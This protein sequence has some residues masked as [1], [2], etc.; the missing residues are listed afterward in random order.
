LRADGR[1]SLRQGLAHQA[2]QLVEFV[3]RVAPRVTD[4]TYKRW[5]VNKDADHSSNWRSI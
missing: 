1:L 3:G 4:P 2:R 5:G